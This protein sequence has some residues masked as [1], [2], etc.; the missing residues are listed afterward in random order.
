MGIKDARAKEESNVACGRLAFGVWC[1]VGRGSR[2]IYVD[3]EAAGSAMG[4]VKLGRKTHRA[5]V[6]RWAGSARSRA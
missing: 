5:G 1:L 6:Y 2:M 4:A 3:R